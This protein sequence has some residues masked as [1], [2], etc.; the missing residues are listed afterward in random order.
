MSEVLIMVGVSAAAF[1]STSLD[2]LFLLMGVAGRATLR[3]RDVAIAYAGALGVVLGAGL[4]GA[5]AL[6]YA[7][8]TA[9]DAWLRFLG[10]LPLAM[11]VWR[12]RALA[13]TGGATQ[14]SQTTSD[15]SC[16]AS[17]F[18][19]MLANSGDSFTVLTSL[20]AESRDA[21]VVVI[22]TTALTMTTLWALLARW[23]VGHPALAPILWRLDRYGVPFLLVAIGLYILLDTPTDTI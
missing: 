8:A 20:M 5:W 23:V 13:T 12:L 22:V 19:L 11:G 9:A 3:T 17:V 2:N 18:A 15:A 4:V 6:G 7:A 10:L 16:R 14:T 21:L 1:V